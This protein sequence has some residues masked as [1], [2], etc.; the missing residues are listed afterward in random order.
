MYDIEEE[1]GLDLICGECGKEGAYWIRDY[2]TVDD[3][4]P[5]CEKCEKEF[6]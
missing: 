6:E 2:S 4:N 1:E 3:Y 5:L